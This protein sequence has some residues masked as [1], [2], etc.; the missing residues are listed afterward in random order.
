MRSERLRT[1]PAMSKCRVL[2]SIP[3]AGASGT[4][5]SLQGL[6]GFVVLIYWLLKVKMKGRAGQC[7]II[8]LSASKGSWWGCAECQ[9]LRARFSNLHLLLPTAS[10]ETSAL[11]TGLFCT[12]RHAV[13]RQM[14]RCAAPWWLGKLQHTGHGPGVRCSGV[15]HRSSGHAAFDAARHVCGCFFPL[16]LLL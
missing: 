1:A 11:Q 10:T 2:L 5:E 13:P 3:G 15:R 7:R 6:G 9:Q 4:A 8:S 14:P 12:K 16:R